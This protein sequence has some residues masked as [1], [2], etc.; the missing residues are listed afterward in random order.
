MTVSWGL[1][2]PLGVS[3]AAIF[4]MTDFGSS[5]GKGFKMHLILVLVGVTF[6]AAGFIVIFVARKSWASVEAQT[7]AILG[8]VSEIFIWAFYCK[9]LNFFQASLS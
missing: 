6:S 9:F 8:L 5:D 7:H 2:M 3:C 4:K 1:F